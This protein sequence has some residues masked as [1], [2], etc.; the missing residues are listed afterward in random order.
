MK[1]YWLSWKLCTIIFHTHDIL[2]VVTILFS[3]NI[4]HHHY[5]HVT[6]LARVSRTLTRHPSLLSIAPGR[7]SRL[8]PV[9]V[10]SWC[11]LCLAGL[12][13]FA[14]PWHEVHGSTS[15]MSSSLLLQQFP[16]CL[17]RQTLIVSVMG[18]RWPYSCFVCVASRTCSIQ[19][20]AFLC[21]CCQAFSF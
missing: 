20:A 8:H 6:L 9:L 12:P 10:H 21:N 5:R 14:R 19:L 7:S 2:Q 4:Y 1:N 13:T 3:A 16:A 11:I 15:L 17:V 18:G